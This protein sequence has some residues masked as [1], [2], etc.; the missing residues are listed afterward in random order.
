MAMRPSSKGIRLSSTAAIVLAVACTDHNPPA[1][2]AIAPGAASRA[3]NGGSAG[4]PVNV[5]N[6]T[7]AQNETP[8]AVNPVN[9]QNMLI[10]ANDWNY[11][12]GCAFGVTFDGGKTWTKAL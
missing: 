1:S 4:K 11:N 9:P 6:D 12:D 8:I 7:T 3:A 10:G 5:T 2:P